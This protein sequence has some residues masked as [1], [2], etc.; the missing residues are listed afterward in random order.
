MPDFAWDPIND[1]ILL[2]QNTSVTILIYYIAF[3]YIFGTLLYKLVI[4]C[5]FIR[6]KTGYRNRT[7]K[8]AYYPF[9]RGDQ[10]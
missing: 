1:S 10:L 4:K 7:L 8:C 5:I 6:Y 2:C 3:H 9:Q